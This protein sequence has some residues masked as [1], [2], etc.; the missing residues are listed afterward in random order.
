MGWVLLLTLNYS[1]SRTLAF[2]SGHGYAQEE[3]ATKREREDL[4]T[5]SYNWCPPIH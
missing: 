3:Y 4:A 5:N 2:D 1:Y